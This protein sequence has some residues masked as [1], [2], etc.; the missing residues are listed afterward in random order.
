[1]V[2]LFYVGDKK[3]PSVLQN[4]GA[5]GAGTSLAQYAAQ[6]RR[7]KVAEGRLGVDQEL[8]AA[9]IE[10]L[11]TSTNMNREQ[12][13]QARKQAAQDNK[14]IHLDVVLAT[15]RSPEHREYM[16]AVIRANGGVDENNIV[17]GK[18]ARTI[19]TILK[20]PM[21]S[22]NIINISYNNAKKKFDAV[23]AAKGNSDLMK[24]LEIKPEQYDQALAEV[25]KDLDAK[26]LMK[27]GYK[28]LSEKT[29]AAQDRKSREAEAE[30]NR[31]SKEKIERAKIAGKEPTQA[32]AVTW[33]LPN[34]DVVR[35]FDGGKTYV[36]E[37]N[38]SVQMPFGAFKF[39][40]QFTGT[41]ISTLKGK[42]AL[43][44]ESKP[45]TEQ[46]SSAIEAAR[47]GTGVW[48]NVGAALDAVAGGVGIDTMLGKDGFFKDTQD[49]RQKLR[50][51]KQLGKS[52]FMNSSRGAI[53]EQK[54]IDKLFPNP[55][56]IFVNP[57]TEARK[58]ESLR[59]ALAIEKDFNNQA[60]EKSANPKEIERFT[61]SNTDID[62]LLAHLGVGEQ[63]G[64]ELP[65]LSPQ[66]E[67][68]LKK[69][70]Y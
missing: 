27:D 10:N 21:H 51:I 2:R 4:I 69:K 18:F 32:K 45:A 58:V 65:A 3:M 41:E 37:N 43:G 5:S 46:S 53:W 38:K 34:L 52:A 48:A 54:K 55:N 40:G 9:R 61:Q 26:E 14:P 23:V 19:P 29:V 67:E 66:A 15:A 70:G 28:E 39:S 1:L 60:M 25:T 42:K 57:S 64:G 7:L 68:W 31:K 36:G 50:I 20:M 30:K 8:G 6:Q 63:Q 33:L 44:K 22:G 35:S 17:R 56:M 47:A 16:E 59:K 11:E 13:L 24:K 49:A 12:V 62:R